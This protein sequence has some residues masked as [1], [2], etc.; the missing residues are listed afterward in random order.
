MTAQHSRSRSSSVRYEPIGMI[1]T[2]FFTRYTH[3][4]HHHHHHHHHQNGNRVRTVWIRMHGAR[5]AF[6]EKWGDH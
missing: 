4:L 2:T 1:H 6:M 3:V 5:T